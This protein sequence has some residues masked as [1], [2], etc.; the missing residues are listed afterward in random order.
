MN[1]LFIS[2]HL[3]TGGITSY[4]LTLGKGLRARGHRVYAASSGGERVQKFEEAGIPVVRVPI[5]TKSEANFLKIFATVRIL[6]RFIRDN[7]I[8][9]VHSHTRVTQVAGYF[10]HRLCRISHVSTCHGF[11]RVRLFRR[12][13]P[14]WGNR[15]IAISEPVRQHLIRDFGISPESIALIYNGI[16]INRFSAVREKKDTGIIK[17]QM[18]VLPGPVVG[19]I[20]RLSDVKGHVYLIEAMKR[21]S[22]TVPNARLL[23]IG[24]GKMKKR[25]VEKVQA[26]RMESSVY[27]IP[28]V[29]DTAEALAAMDVFVMPSLQEGL[30]LGLMEAMAAGLPVIGSDVGG[31]RSLIIREKTGILVEPGNP[32]SIASAITDVLTDTLKAEMLGKNARKFIQSNF[33]SETMVTHTEKLY[34][35]LL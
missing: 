26:L 27:F 20:A 1:I 29:E 28:E 4:L 5:N 7:N 35:S 24:D 34:A 15:V 31:I 17:K 33:N 3:N 2:T 21:V 25:L 9:L 19:I 16:D 23:I 11:F 30:G 22:D 18:G 8:H 12:I 13:F 32:V 14:C 10:L 6:K